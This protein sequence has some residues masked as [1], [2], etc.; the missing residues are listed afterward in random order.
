MSEQAE[1]LGQILAILV[2]S[3]HVLEVHQ[4]VDE[5]AHDVGEAGD[6]DEQNESCHDSLDLTLGI[7]VTKTD[8][9]QCGEGEVNHNDQVLPVAFLVELVLVVEG[10]LGRLRVQVGRVFRDDE[11]DGADEVRQDQDK[12]DQA[13]DAEDVHEIDL[14]HDLVIVFSH[15]LQLVFFL[16]VSVDTSAVE[17]LQE[18]LEL[19]RI[20]KEEN[21]V[22]TEKSQ[23]VEQVNLVVC[24]VILEDLDPEDARNGDEVDEEVAL[25]VPFRDALEVAHAALSTL[26]IILELHE[27]VANDIDAEAHFH[28]DINDLGKC[29]LG[30][31]KTRIEGGQERRDESEDDHDEPVS[32]DHLV[33]LADDQVV[34]GVC[35]LL[36]GLLVH[37]GAVN[38]GI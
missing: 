37:L 27:E 3:C 4:D 24:P 1:P 18:A 38:H 35:L 30:R 2:V 34:T 6:A 31:S 28:D 9:G 26:V 10:E 29:R 8:S 33:I 11:P 36:G 20:Q 23:Q 13:E 7:V 15:W 17:A 21:L 12:K 25:E 16:H 19:L 14:V 22:E 32:L 5:L